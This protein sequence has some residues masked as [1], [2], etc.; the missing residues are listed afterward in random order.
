MV[1]LGRDAKWFVHKLEFLLENATQ[2]NPPG[3]N[4]R[5]SGKEKKKKRILRRVD[6]GDSVEHRVKIK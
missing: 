1:K 3:Q 2:K 4:T 5:P 6:F